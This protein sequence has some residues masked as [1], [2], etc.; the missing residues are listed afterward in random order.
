MRVIVCGAG[1]VGYDVAAYLAREDNDVTVVDQDPTLVARVNDALD[2]KGVLGHA[3]SPDVL[4]AAGAAE[5][6]LILAVT[7]QDEVNMVACQVAHSLFGVPK[8]IA[9][10]RL[11]AYLDPAHSNLFSRAHMPIDVLISPEVAIAEDI[12]ERLS[13]PGTSLVIPLAGGAAYLLGVV[14]R[15]DCPLLHTPLMQIPILFPD[16]ALHILALVQG[17]R[18]MPTGPASQIGVGDTVFFVVAAAHRVRALEAFGRRD[19]RARRVLIAGGGNIGAALTRTLR[20][21]ERQYDLTIVE[22]NEARAQVLSETF[23]DLIVL[24]GSSLEHSILEEASVGN[25]DTIVAVTS[26]DETNILASLL[27]KQCGC[28][29]ALALVAGASYASL[30]GSL[31]IDALISPRATLVTQI[32]RH[33]RRGRIR[34][35][36]T[37][38][39]GFA[40]IMEV[41]VV[42]G[43]PL[44]GHSSG[45]LPLPRAVA[46]T[47]II[48]GTDVLMPVPDLVLRPGDLA[49]LMVPQGQAR[50]VEKALHVRVSLF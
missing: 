4:A 8:K 1:Q 45:D 11:P 43:G 17:G 28:E 40:E 27:A 9:R 29:R 26:S 20:E 3:S 50:A 18:P 46:L 47:A 12:D 30:V 39:E 19:P 41:E 36:H 31:G 5:A 15:A 16:L 23:S 35:V 14:C 34:A 42:E 48:R 13:V 21:R 38:R 2:A 10:V 24:H 49:I 7:R 6:D 44:A 22:A 32:M 33:V 25:V 37:L